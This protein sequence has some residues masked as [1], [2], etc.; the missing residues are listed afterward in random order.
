MLTVNRNCY[1]YY[2]KISKGPGGACVRQRGAPVP[3]HNGQSKPGATVWCNISKYMN[4]LSALSDSNETAVV[5]SDV[6]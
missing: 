2:Q 5:T 1:H 6:V 3:W 4:K